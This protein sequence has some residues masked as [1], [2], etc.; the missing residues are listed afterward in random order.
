[1]PT[2]KEFEEQS[3][4]IIRQSHADFGDGLYALSSFGVESALLP[5]LIQKSGVEVPIITIDTGFWFDETH[6][7][8]QQLEKQLGFTAISYRPDDVTLHNIFANRLWQKD[9]K[10]YR[11]HTKLAPLSEAIGELGV[12][13]LLTGIKAYQNENRAQ[14]S[15]YGFVGR[16][17][18]WRI[19][20]TIEWTEQAVQEYFAAEDLPYHPLYHQGY[21][22]IDDWPLTQPG[23][24][25][26]G[27]QLDT[28]SECGLHIPAA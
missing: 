21:E 1:M 3:I 11:Q 16:D 2:Y 26:E 8:K 10:A 9:L 18:E 27:R 5:T 24:G 13:A 4:E 12:D 15:K 7:H 19:H 20:P 23:K 22:S 17:E 6:A 14:L 25:R 28:K